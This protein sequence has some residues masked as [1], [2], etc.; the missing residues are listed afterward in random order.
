MFSLGML[1]LLSQGRPRKSP[2]GWSGKKVP[3]CPLVAMSGSTHSSL[4]E[5]PGRSPSSRGAM[6]PRSNFRGGRHAFRSGCLGVPS[7]GLDRTSAGGLGRYAAL[8]LRLP[9][10]AAPGPSR[11][12]TCDQDVR[13]VP[14]GSSF[15]PGSLPLQYYACVGLSSR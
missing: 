4:R 5:P 10:T 3:S 12:T 6:V 14:S 1:A 9:G 15:K 8:N 11:T 7:I 2:G 13:A